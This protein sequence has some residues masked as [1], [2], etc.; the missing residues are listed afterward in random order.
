MQVDH[1]KGGIRILLSDRD[2]K[3]FGTDFAA[4]R[5]KDER[6]V[7]IIRR[8]LHT[9]CAKH[10]F[11]A[12]TILTVEALPTVDGCFLLVTPQL[13]ATIRIYSVSLP[14]GE[15]FL[16]LAAA[17]N[18]LRQTIYASSLYTYQDAYRLLIYGCLSE[19]ALGLLQEFAEDI[20]T[21]HTAAAR[22]QEYG[23]PVCIGSALITASAPPLPMLQDPA[24]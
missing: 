3:R 20:Q 21:G 6:T 8:I 12:Q 24:H 18:R 22:V 5:E 17:W 9:V 19:S 1:S 13:S 2:L 14:D 16:S 4:L 15:T 23:T 7:R 11:P 10:P